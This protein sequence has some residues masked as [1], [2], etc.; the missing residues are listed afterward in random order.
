MTKHVF[1]VALLLAAFV[2]K[3]QKKAADI[4]G[5]SFTFSTL[6][7][8]P[9]EQGVCRRDPSDI[10]EVKGVY[11]LYYTRTTTQYSGYNATVW[12]ATSRD[13]DT[14]KEQGEALPRGERGTWDAYSV[15]TPN[16]LATKGKYY[17]FYTGVKPTEG[18]A[19]R[20]FE[21]NSTNDITAIGLAVAANPNGP[22][23]RVGQN[24]ILEISSQSDD[25]DSYRVDDACIIYRNQK[26]YLYYKGRSRKYGKQGPRHTKMGVA[27]ADKPTGPYRKYE[28][29]PIIKGGHE[30]MVWPYEKGVMTLLSS[31][32]KEGKTLQYAKDGLHFKPVVAFGNDYPKAPGITKEFKALKKRDLWGVSMRY[33]TAETWPYLLKYQIKIK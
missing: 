18:N 9:P 5:V 28:Q 30:V 20:I 10:I 22:F 24:P 13:G 25:F 27:M 29:N 2:C 6:K 7:G 23:E 8:L 3:A 19:K 17:L 32:G 16:I 33:G 12:Y 15:F 11:Y 4:K 26:Y 1:C 14:W 31:V 21:N